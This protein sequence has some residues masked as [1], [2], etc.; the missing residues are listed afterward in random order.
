MKRRMRNALWSS[1]FG[2]SLLLLCGPTLFAQANSSASPTVRHAGT[3]WVTA[4]LRELAKLP[5]RPHYVLRA[6]SPLRQSRRRPAGAVVDTVEQSAPGGGSNFSIFENGPGLGLGFGG[7]DTTFNYPD[8]NIAVGKDQIV[9]IVNNSVAVFDKSLNALTPAIPISI[10]LGEI[11]GECEADTPEGHPIAQ[12]DRQAGQ[13][14]IAE[15]VVSARPY[16]GTA[17]I[18]VST[19]SDATG[20]YYVYEFSLG[21]GYPDLAKWATWPPSFIQSSD[22]F[23]SDAH[24]YMGPD[25]CVYNRAKM[26]AGDPSA[27]QICLGSQLTTNDFALM[28]A[29]MDSPALPPVGEDEFLFSLW[30]SSNLA[31]YSIHVDWPTLT[32]SITGGDGSQLFPVPPFNP[33]CNG[34]Y[35]AACVPQLGSPDLL[36]VEGDRLLYRV[37]YYNGVPPKIPPN[38]IPPSFQHWLVLHDVTASGGNTAER[39][40]EF[41]SSIKNIPVTSIGLLQSGTYAPDDVNYRWTGSIARDMNGDIMLGY[42]ESSSDIYPSIAITGRTVSDPPGTMEPELSVLNGDGP[43]NDVFDEDFDRW[44]DYTS[45]RLDP[46]DNCTFWY[47]SEYY[48]TTG[49]PGSSWST[50]INSARFS[51]CPPTK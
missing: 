29:D 42:S 50:Q 12:Y 21:D 16:K 18:L 44:G 4:P 17:C 9:Q 28:P 11:G 36:D 13:W 32:A 3:F 48:S 40:Y 20:N 37:A 24:T 22:N 27:E 5:A 33:A 46:A 43:Y 45:M 15:N 31:L 14:L 6:N 38:A 47:T 34:Q 23:G 49:L 41:Y 2:M 7:F 10:L 35:L 30:D 25:P 51:G 19:S 8:D 39:W 1:A 26:L